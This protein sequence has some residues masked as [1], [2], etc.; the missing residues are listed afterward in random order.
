MIF[1]AT[2][3]LKLSITA[4]SMAVC[5]S[6]ITATSMAVCGSF[7]TAIAIVDWESLI[8]ATQMP[9]YFSMPFDNPAYPGLLEHYGVKGIP[10]CTG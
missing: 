2:F 4:T 9:G 5:G 1:F 7:L 3:F 8:S 6:F 10:T